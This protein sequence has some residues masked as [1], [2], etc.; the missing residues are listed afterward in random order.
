MQNSG[1]SSL[2]VEPVDRGHGE[3]GG[4][5]DRGHGQPVAGPVLE[6]AV[7]HAHALS[8]ARPQHHAAHQLVARRAELAQAQA[9]VHQLT[10]LRRQPPGLGVGGARF[11]QC[12]LQRRFQGL[13]CVRGLTG[14][15]WR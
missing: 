1:E 7:D 15:P 9:R 2:A 11:G 3:E 14:L 6:R 8:G 4:V 5:G 13:L 10:Q 12:C